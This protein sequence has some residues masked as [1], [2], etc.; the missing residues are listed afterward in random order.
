M[1]LNG[2][3]LDP[4]DAKAIIKEIKNNKHISQC[5]SEKQKLIKDAWKNRDFLSNK[6]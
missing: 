1:E 4:N 3:K 5:S 6:P 2:K